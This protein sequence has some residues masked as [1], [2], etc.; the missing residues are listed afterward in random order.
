MNLT[1]QSPIPLCSSSPQM[2][3]LLLLT[4]SSSSSKSHIYSKFKRKPIQLHPTLTLKPLPPIQ[5]STTGTT[6]SRSNRLP[7]PLTSLDSLT[8]YVRSQWRPI[9]AGWLCSAASAYSLSLIVPKIGRFSTVMSSVSA[10]RMREEALAIGALALVRLI[11]SYWQQAFL[12]DAALMAL[13][14]IRVFV[15][16]RVLVRDLGF[17]E[18]GGGVSAGDIAYRITAEASDVADTVYA[19]LNAIVPSI[20]QLSAMA[21]QMLIISPVLLFISVLVIP[22]MIIVTGYLGEKLRKI[23]KKAHLSIAALSAYL[24][25]V[26][27]SILFVK[28]NNAELSEGARFRWLAHADLSEH[29]NKKKMKALVPQ[30][31][32]MIYF[33]E[34]L[35]F[36]VGSLVVSGGSL[37]CCGMVSFVTSL[38]FLIEPIQ[39]VGK[40]YN[41]LKQG[42]PAIER[43]FDL[44]RFQSKVIEKPGAGNLDFVTGEVKFC[45][46]SFKYADDMPLVLNG[47]DLHIKA[48]ET[49]ALVGPS[50]GGKTTL[51]KLLLRLYD[52]LCGCILIDN[53]NIQSIRLESLRRH[54]GLVSQ[55]ITLFSGTV[56]ENIGYRD[57]MT[58]IDMERVKL[59]ARTANADEFIEL[60]PEQYETNIGSRGSILSGGQKQRLAIARAVYQNSSILIL[61]EATSALDSRSELLVR[62]AVQRLMGNRTVLVI[63]HRL[64]TVLMAKR[65]FLLDDGKF[66]ELQHS[67]L[68]D[69]QHGTLVSSG[70]VI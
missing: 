38:V 39:G 18:G 20:L 32:Q 42:E 62:Q 13:Y 16:E 4:P 22:L 10:V 12:W 9:L 35:I 15:F 52:P 56:A 67:S 43:L 8:P 11:A 65:V 33:G 6:A 14:E 41:E 2:A 48:G 58:K 25:E 61:D 24:N 29:L 47:L 21:T 60:L 28:A 36:C 44:T 17:F 31:I 46:V 70:L 7:R 23:S 3:L 19:L 66:E 50:G 55:D 57:L 34:L 49:V 40:A 53:H 27:P 68:L 30:I 69:G 1:Y 26:L 45:D 63:A 51:A 64:E 59:A 5:S 54:V 37:D